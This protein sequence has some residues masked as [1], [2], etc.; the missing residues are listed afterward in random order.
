MKRPKALGFTVLELLVAIGIASAI[1]S[2]AVPGLLSWLP[3]LRLSAAARQVSMD[4]RVARTKAI[5]QNT[6]FQ[7]S[8]NGSFYVIRKCAGTCADEGGNILLPEGITVSASATP[9]FFSRGTAGGA[10]TITLSNGTESRRVLV[11][12]VGRV[13]VL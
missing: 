9:Q 13:L 7:V 5:A 3:T 11:S 8:F 6:S 12:A 1:A 2:V 4:L 10:A